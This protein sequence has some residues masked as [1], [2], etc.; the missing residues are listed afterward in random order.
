M[1]QNERTEIIQD[2]TGW[3]GTFRDNPVEIGT[4]TYVFELR[5]INGEEEI[6]AGSVNVFR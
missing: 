2:D 5:F 6:R 1:Y 3:D 4:Y